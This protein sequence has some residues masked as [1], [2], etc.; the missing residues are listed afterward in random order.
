MSDTEAPV[1]R[2]MAA[3][4]VQAAAAVVLAAT[5]GLYALRLAA[6]L[7]VPVLVALLGAY[8]LEPIV[9]T[10]VRCRVPRVVAALALFFAAA[11]VAGSIGRGVRN[12]VAGFLDDLPSAIAAANQ[13]FAGTPHAVGTGPLGPVERA[14][15]EM[16]RAAAPARVAGAMPVV[17]VHP[18]FDVR[19]YLLEAT[20]GILASAGQATA[21]VLLMFLLLASGDL[22]KRKLVNFAG[23][24]W[25]DKRRAVEVLHLIDRQIERYLLARVAISAIVAVATGA[26][27]WWIDLRNAAVW[28]IV[29]GVLNVMPFIGPAVACALIALAAFLQFHTIEMTL[30]A[31]AASGIVA[32]LEGNVITPWLTSRAGE[33]NTVAVFLSVLFWGWLWDVWGLLLA[34]P[35]MVA[36]K[37]AA[38]RIEPLQPIGELLGR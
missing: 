7:V 10:M 11:L 17:V 36:V 27:L 38:D 9:A 22:Y 21:V 26:A 35:I 25:G 2:A 1:E 13:T 31:G 28:G 33:L 16:H 12:Q 3:V 20:R 23:P 18:P 29:A 14:A 30:A 5:A 37:A 15:A 19:E 24:T 32:A 34:V 8:A 6:P 4:N